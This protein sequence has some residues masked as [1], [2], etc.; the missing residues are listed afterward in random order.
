MSLGF[1]TFCPH[2][3]VTTINQVLVLGTSFR[4]YPWWYGRM[5]DAVGAT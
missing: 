1:H 3:P 2:T 4:A 5:Y